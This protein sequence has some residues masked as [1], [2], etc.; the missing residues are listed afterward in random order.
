MNFLPFRELPIGGGG[1]SQEP[2]DINIIGSDTTNLQIKI[3]PGTVNGIFPTNWTSTL[4]ASVAGTIFCYVKVTT[5]GTSVTNAVITLDS[6]YNPSQTPVVDS[7]PTNFQYCFGI[8]VD[9]S[10]YRTMGGGSII[11]WGNTQYIKGKTTTLR[12]GELPYD[13]YNVWVV[14]AEGDPRILRG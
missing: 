8:I 2:F 5:N 14:K 13:A 12:P 4:T 6:S 9:G 11:A 1:S 7:L 3:N 10:T